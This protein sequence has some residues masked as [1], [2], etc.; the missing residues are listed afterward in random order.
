[1]PFFIMDIWHAMHA[2][3]TTSGWITLAIMAVIALGAGYMMSSFGSLV[4]TT[5]VALV[6]F[7]LVSYARAI[8]LG[9]QKAS[10]YAATDWQAFQNLH[11]LDLLAYALLFAIVIA[12]AHAARSLIFGR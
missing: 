2:I 12:V 4:S 5:V 6:A 1:M 9:G 8:T 3:L 10:A 7:A 11:M